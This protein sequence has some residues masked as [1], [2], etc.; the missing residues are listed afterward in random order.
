[1]IPLSLLKLHRPISLR[2][3]A[4]LFR[5]SMRSADGAEN[6][7]IV[8]SDHLAVSVPFTATENNPTIF[9][10]ARL[11]Y[12]PSNLVKPDKKLMNALMTKARQ[13]NP[14]ESSGCFLTK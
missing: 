13:H 14:R 7:M 2:Q 6:Q 9:P 5:E 4:D 10:H 8:E 1:M 11:K 3:P 12:E